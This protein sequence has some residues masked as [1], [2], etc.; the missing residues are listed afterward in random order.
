MTFLL[1]PRR[2][3]PVLI[4]GGYNRVEIWDK[5]VEW[6]AVNFVVMDETDSGGYFAC[7]GV[8]RHSKIGCDVLKMAILHYTC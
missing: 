7:V 3:V 1:L 8:Q 5:C 2:C 6:Q 4:S